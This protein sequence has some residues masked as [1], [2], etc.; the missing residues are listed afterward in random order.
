MTLFVNEVQLELFCR[1][2]SCNKVSA[3]DANDPANM[4]SISVPA[5]LLGLSF[6]SCLHLQLRQSTDGQIK[7]SSVDDDSREP[8]HDVNGQANGDVNDE[9]E[10]GDGDKRKEA[11]DEGVPTHELQ[12]WHKVRLKKI[13]TIVV[14]S[15][16]DA[17]A[18]FAFGWDVSSGVSKKFEDVLM[19]AFWVSPIAEDMVSC[20]DSLS[21]I[22][23]VSRAVM[24]V[25][26]PA[27]YSRSLAIH[28][29]YLH[30]KPGVHRRYQSGMTVR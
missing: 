18:C 17:V 10:E 11:D 2:S 6:L 24:P 29:P 14:L 12:W 25:I 15:L 5:S 22:D 21:T 4:T 9:E 13:A 7:L 23:T 3:D 20:T 1:L 19:I 28:G 16:V 8:Y 27:R 26:W 30:F